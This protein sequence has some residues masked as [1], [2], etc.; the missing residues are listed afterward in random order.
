M[1]VGIAYHSPLDI[2]SIFPLNVMYS[3]EPQDVVDIFVSDHLVREY[4]AKLQIVFTSAR[5]L[6][7]ENLP[8]LDQGAWGKVIT[9]TT[10]QI[11]KLL[12]NQKEFNDTPDWV[13]FKV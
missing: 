12:K 10:D 8:I 13:D 3:V 5:N 6:V 1:I 9:V 7:K 11:E 4:K 2:V